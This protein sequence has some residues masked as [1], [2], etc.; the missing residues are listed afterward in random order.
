MNEN[1]ITFR[2][3]RKT[4][5]KRLKRDNAGRLLLRHETVVLLFLKYVQKTTL[6]KLLEMYEC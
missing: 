1:N 6:R 3:L 4:E 2:F 5:F